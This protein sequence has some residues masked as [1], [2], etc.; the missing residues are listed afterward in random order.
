MAGSAGTGVRIEPQVQVLS[1]APGPTIVFGAIPRGV[2][3]VAPN[4][5]GLRRLATMRDAYA[6]WSPDGRSLLIGANGGIYRVS[7]GVV[8]RLQSGS[9]PVWSPDGTRIA[10]SGSAGFYVARADGTHAVRIARQFS[11]TDPA[12]AWSPDGRRIAYATCS[13]PGSQGCAQGEG[14][15]VFVTSARGGAHRRITSKKLG[16]QCLAWSSRGDI[17]FGTGDNMTGIVE[18]SGRVRTFYPGGCPSA[19]APNGSRYVVAIPR[20]LGFLNADGGGRRLLALHIPFAAASYS[21][22]VWSPDGTYVAF[23]VAPY[24]GSPNTHNELYVVRPDGSG[25]RHVPLPRGG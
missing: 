22:P 2:Y 16:V 8:R 13:E 17:L 15:A 21:D 14:K 19:W 24:H 12:V 20:G 9:S 6:S 23:L 18:P 1:W 11:E 3:A 25:L 5:S 4:G 10:F 7:G